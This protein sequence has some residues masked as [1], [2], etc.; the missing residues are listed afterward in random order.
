MAVGE[1]AESSAKFTVIEGRGPIYSRIF[2]M[3]RETKNQLS[4]ITTVT[5][6]TRADQF[7]LFDSGFK[8]P[9]KYMPQFR[10]LTE[11]SAQ[12]IGV[13]KKL[14][15][16]MKRT[17]FKFEGRTPEI[18][19]GLFPQMVIKD[20]AEAIFFITA[21]TELNEACLWTNCKSLVNA[22]L[23]V[24]EDLWRTAINV[25]EK[26]E[27]IENSKSKTETSTISNSETARRKY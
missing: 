13:M 3:V 11:L 20:D 14:L 17:N 15:S 21:P 9:P 12:G 6:L 4:S 1:S 25:T 22:F 8:D 16:E 2:Q 5:G 27:E 18:G 10:F 19:L 7:G 23:A 26:M 24:F